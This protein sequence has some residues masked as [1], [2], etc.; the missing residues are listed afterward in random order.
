MAR[1]TEYK[2]FAADF[3]TT[4]FKG[5]ESTEVWAAAC[6]ELY[7]EDSKIFHSIE[8]QFEYFRKTSGNICAYYHNLKFD[9]SFWLYFLLNV[10]KYKTAFI[11][12]HFE[13]PKLFEMKNNTFMYNISARGQWYSITIKTN[14]K[15][16]QLR[17]SLKL[18]PF[19]LAEI[20]KAFE[21]K[22]R[23]LEMEYTG[24]RFAGCEIKPEEK[25]YILNDVLVL[26][27]ALEYMF[28]NGHTNLT[29]GACCLQEFKSGFHH[30]DYSYLFPDMYEVDTPPE[31]EEKTAGDFIKHTYRG[32]WC[33]VVEEKAKKIIKNGITLDVNSLY[34]SVMHSESGC[35]YPH[36]KPTFW[37]GDYIPD[38]ANRGDY[39]YFVKIKTRFFLK[40]N[41]LPCIQ[42][43]GDLKYK[44]TEW[45]RT[46]N[47]KI[48]DEEVEYYKDLNGNIKVA[49]PTLYLTKTDFE[50]IKEHYYLV[51]TEIIGGCYFYAI[52]GLF[53]EYID[54]YKKI[55]TTSKG[56][57]RTLAKLF[58]NNLYGKMATST[59]SSFKIA[60]INENNALY[61]KTILE[62]NKKAGYIPIGSAIT[63][64]ARN[65]TIRAAQKNFY[66]ADKAGFIYADTDSIHCDI[67]IEK[68]KGVELHDSD[69]CKWKLEKEWDIGY[70]V[71]Q[72]TYI[73][74]KESY[75]ITCAG[76]PTRCK[77]LLKKSMGEDIE[78]GELTERERYFL[79][80]ERRIL[81]FDTGLQIPSKLRP[82]N[83]TGGVLLEDSYFTMK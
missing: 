79:E 42:I 4:V 54:K 45:L 77:N 9:G 71:R 41:Y 61:Y 10:K 40:E 38:K 2:Y 28:D 5:Q 52:T 56:A 58:S 66:G 50:L 74:K 37:S 67:P 22:H 7:T 32:G 59:D 36:G 12:E 63:S 26:K 68:V 73:E 14:G 83:I 27:E 70:F 33:Y 16:I 8:E 49:R 48:D 17:D 76:M 11:G 44:P 31:F 21:T 24:F 13:R 47:I 60:F 18:M 62:N 53:D 81:D 64:Y 23:K 25:E 57:K 34:P 19:T 65:F 69:Y 82:V 43:K 20:G 46:S 15:I 51:D 78:L 6:C 80:K 39:Y 55:K 29:I 35:V 75:D 72:K 30:D 1:T 3:E